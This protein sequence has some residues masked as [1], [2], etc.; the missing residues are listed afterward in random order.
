MKVISI[1]NQKGGVGKTTTAINLSAYLAK[2]GKKILLV[3]MDPQGNASSGLGIEKTGLSGSTYDL[4]LEDT[5]LED[6]IKEVPS[7]KNLYISP[8]SLELASADLV[9]VGIEDRERALARRREEFMEGKFDFVI[10]DC[11][12]SLG[13]L[14]VNALTAS[15]TVIIPVQSEYFAMEGIGMLVDTI[16]RV[17]KGLNR[18]LKIEGVLLSMYD[19]RKNLNIEVAR[20]LKKHF[21]DMVYDTTIPNNVRLAEAPSF[22]L[23]VFEYD[24]KC[25]GAEAYESFSEEF[26]RRNGEK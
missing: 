19:P 12:P 10:I 8:S 16:N 22:G 18:D 3:D 6:I 13:L 15:D 24:P 5:G 7:V 20:E 9:L 25:R 26:L 14:S 4:L 21:G 17:N 23:P 1:F 2:K 11:P